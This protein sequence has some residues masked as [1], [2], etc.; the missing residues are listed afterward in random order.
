MVT[1]TRIEAVSAM[2]PGGGFIKVVTV[3]KGRHRFN[4]SD[5]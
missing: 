3:T 5:R 2:F 1:N 4:D